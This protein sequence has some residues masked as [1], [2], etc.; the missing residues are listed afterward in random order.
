M[1]LELI[2]KEVVAIWDFT[3]QTEEL[4]FIRSHGLGKVSYMECDEGWEGIDLH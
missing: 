3:I 2:L 1:Y 4:L